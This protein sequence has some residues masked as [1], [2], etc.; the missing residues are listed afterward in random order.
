MITPRF[1][2]SR[3]FVVGSAAV[4]A[5]GALALVTGQAPS[6][7]AA[8]AV[9]NPITF[10]SPTVVDNY[11]PGYE[12]DVAVD[13]SPGDSK[14]LY[15]ST[16]FGFSTTQSF[17]ESSNDLGDS[18][19]LTAGNIAG[20]PANCVGGG[21]TEAQI[22]PVNGSLYFADLQGLTNYSASRS[23]NHGASFD[24]SCASVNGTAVDR[25]WIGQDNNGNTSAVG[26]GANDGRL[27]FDY[28]NVEQSTDTQHVFDRRQNQLVH[29][30]VPGRR[31]VRL[32][33]RRHDHRDGHDGRLRL[34][35]RLP[36]PADGHQQQ[37]RACRAT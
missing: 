3:S 22:D 32:Q 17:I 24:A 35:H 9:T 37:T 8:A 11:R 7:G 5:I 13:H 26:P 1:R 23:D 20:K 36:R 15:T 10:A 34:D 4:A 21:D 19:H 28:D 30:R 31:S 29:Q 27:Y 16:P 25:Q 6:A 2:N 12:P 14:L 18:F 33:L